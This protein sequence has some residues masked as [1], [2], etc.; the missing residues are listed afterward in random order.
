VPLELIPGFSATKFTSGVFALEKLP[1]ASGLGPGHA[2]GIVPD[3]GELGNPNDYLGRDMQWH[4]FDADKVYQPTVPSPTIVLMS[5]S[6]ELQSIHISCSLAGSTLFV[7]SIAV[8][9]SQVE[10]PTSMSVPDGFYI[11][12]YAAKS[13]YNN[14]DISSYKVTTPLSEVT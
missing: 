13:G 3:P 12:A 11:E 1:V 4:Q 6:E 8:V 2:A 14:S 10:N 9:F 7:R 5:W